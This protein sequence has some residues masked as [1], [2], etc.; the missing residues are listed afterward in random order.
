MALTTFAIYEDATGNV[1]NLRN[2]KKDSPPTAPDGCSV[3][4]IGLNAPLPRCADYKVV[5]GVFTDRPREEKDTAANDLR[6]RQIEF[7]LADLDNRKAALNARSFT[8]A[9]ALVDAEIASLLAEHASL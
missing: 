6:K 1:C 2:G 4:D 5:D 7:A 8:E 3:L 9:E